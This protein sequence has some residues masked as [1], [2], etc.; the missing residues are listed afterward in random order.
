MRNNEKRWETIRSAD[1]RL[2]KEG[3]EKEEEKAIVRSAPYG[4]DNHHYETN[5][6][7]DAGFRDVHMHKVFSIM[8]E[9]KDK[10]KPVSLQ[11]TL[12]DANR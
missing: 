6:Q 7:L 10:W 12:T 5:D 11:T 3:E 4:S 2:E 1:K 9:G 8:D